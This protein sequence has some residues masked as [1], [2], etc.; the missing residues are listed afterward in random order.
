MGKIVRLTES[1]LINVIQKIVKENISEEVVQGKGSDP[2]Q[3]KKEG[4]K[5]FYAKKG[6]SNWMVQTNPDAID[7]IE[8]KIF[9]TSSKVGG[10][11]KK[12]STAFGV[13]E[14]LGEAV[15]NTVKFQGKVIK[16]IFFDGPVGLLMI[17]YSVWK[18]KMDLLRKLFSFIGSLASKVG[19]FVIEKGKK[20]GEKAVDF[21]S[22]ASTDVKAGIIALFSPI[23]GIGYKAGMAAYDLAKKIPEI[24][25]YVKD[26]FSDKLSKLGKG[27]ES[28][29]EYVKKKAGDIYD[30]GSEFVKGVGSGIMGEEDIDMMLEN[31]HYYNS[32][33]LRKMINEIR[34]DTRQVIY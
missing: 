25:S 19:G 31:Y 8:N 5:Y 23:L 9:G 17:G 11:G 34:I 30:M 7:A 4:D 6:S 18:L 2:F 21:W 12:K 27:I 28:G 20:L 3:Y 15:V 24:W 14:K 33:P 32:L 29:Y 13:G 26:W 22:K 1:E 16:F 10:G